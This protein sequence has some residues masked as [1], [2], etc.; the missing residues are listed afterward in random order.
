MFTSPAHEWA[1]R[2]RAPNNR[3]AA[4]FVRQDG[5][6][7][8]MPSPIPSTEEQ[9]AM[10][11]EARLDLR[12]VQAFST[13]DLNSVPAPKLLCVKEGEPVVR[14]YVVHRRP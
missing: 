7:L 12:E 9:I 2:F 8:L 10:F 13:H 11:A 3:D 5:T 4:E 1:T 6:V 14:G